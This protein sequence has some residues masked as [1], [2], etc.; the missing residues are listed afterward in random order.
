M[1]I[2]AMEENKAGKGNEECRCEVGTVILNM[3]I[4]KWLPKVTFG[5]TCK[6]A[7]G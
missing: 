3:V 2:H 5:Q 4:R 1:V 7:V 6:G